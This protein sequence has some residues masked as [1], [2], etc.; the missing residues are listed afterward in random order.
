MKIAYL[1][2]QY[3][4][5][6]HSFIRSEILALESVGVPVVRIAIRRSPEPLVTA[7]DY[8]E[9]EKTHYILHSGSIRLVVG[10]LF[11]CLQRPVKALKMLR[12][13]KTLAA[14]AGGRWFKHMAYA[15]EGAAM[16]RLC[17]SRKIDHIHCHFGTNATAVALFARILGGPRYS[18]TVH[19]PEEFD[20]PI[21]LSIR[22]KAKFADS[23]IAISL[24][25]RSQLYR[26]CRTEDWQKIH[27]VHCTVAA[28]FLRKPAKNQV[29]SGRLLSIGR[30]C[31]QKGHLI[32]LRAIKLVIDSGVEVRL[33]LIGD[34]EMR[35]EVESE[36]ARLDLGS[37]VEILGWKSE[38]EII[39][40]LDK[41]ELFVLA[42]FAE[43]L[44]VVIME[45]LAR[46]LPVISTYVA[47]IPEL[48]KSGKSGWLVHP[49][50][51]EVL[52]D[53]ITIALNTPVFEKRKFGQYGK[54]H[55]ISDYG[56]SESLKLISIFSSGEVLD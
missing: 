13:Y 25:C 50:D 18:F 24:F 19:G 4:R 49:G 35:A 22:E 16:V 11:L 2:N 5:V 32:V 47:G 17:E 15:I 52:A 40:E 42:S 26:W 29:Q 27:I 36:V 51:P 45:A 7:A 23:V 21:R 46:E 9:Q 31:E 37:Q 8:Q 10:F 20:Y 41:A 1:V 48:V 39:S 54:Q 3:P 28:N 6:S 34:G 30:L 55:I 33:Q 43:G 38:E 44:P 56:P 53:C 14:N 12:W